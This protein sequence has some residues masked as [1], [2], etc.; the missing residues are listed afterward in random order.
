MSHTS[1]PTL[2]LLAG[3][4]PPLLTIASAAPAAIGQHQRSTLQ[5][6]GGSQLSSRLQDEQEPSSG[7]GTIARFRRAHGDF[8]AGSGVRAPIRL[9][10]NY[11]PDASL[12]Q[13]QGSFDLMEWDFKATVPIPISRDWFVV[14]GALAGQRRYQFDGVAGLFDE[15]LHRYDLRLGVGHFVDDDLMVQAYWQPGIYSDLDGTL[16]AEDWRLWYA[17]AFAVWRTGEDLFLKVGALVTDAI[18]TTAVPAAGFAWQIDDRWRLDVLLP[19]DAELSYQATDGLRLFVGLDVEA[20][21]Y[22]IRNPAAFG[23]MRRSVNVQEVYAFAGFEQMLDAH[24]SFF[25]RGGTT[26]TGRYE[27]G[28]GPGTPN[29]EGELEPGWFGNFGFGFRF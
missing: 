15:T 29:Y 11:V 12:E 24:F 17:R 7:N 27:W 14:G 13:E 21:E 2:R 19:K 6:H 20:D 18:D 1:P 9:A 25:F 23:K 3:C 26:V 8:F 4:L 5:A 16:H 28:Y 10:Y 22:H